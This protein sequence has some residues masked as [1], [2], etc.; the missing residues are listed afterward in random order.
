MD[1]NICQAWQKPFVARAGA[2]YASL[3]SNKLA[4]P[5]NT[6][7]TLLNA[8]ILTTCG[9]FHM[10]EIRVHRAR[11]LVAAHGFESA[12]GHMA[13]AQLMSNLLKI[14]CPMERREYRQQVGDL[15][16]VLRLRTRLPEGTTLI[17]LAEFE[18][19]GYSL[20]L[21]ERFA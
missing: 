12:I 11:N 8:P 15:V 6:P 7:I 5:K 16:V 21:L 10:H 2:D 13:T 14:A 19:V 4:M 9:S 20:T 17:T 18:S 1:T 3:Q